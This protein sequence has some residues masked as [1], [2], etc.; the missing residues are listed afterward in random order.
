M[1]FWFYLVCYVSLLTLP[2]QTA[3]AQEKSANSPLVQVSYYV[4]KEGSLRV[5]DIEGKKFIPTPIPFSRGYTP[6]VTWMKVEV[7]PHR[8]PK[9]VLSL[10]P[11]YLDDVRLYRLDGDKGWV[12][13]QMGDHFPFSERIRKERVFAFNITPHPTQTSLFFLRV[14]TT[15]VS[16]FDI[17]VQ[18]E[19]DAIALDSQVHILIGIYLGLLLA[20]ILVSVW[21][22]IRTR[23]V[24]WMIDSFF[25]FVSLCLTIGYMGFSAKYFLPH[26]PLWADAWVSIVALLHMASGNIFLHQFILRYKP[27]RWMIFSFVLID[28]VIP[29]LGFTGLVLGQVQTVMSINALFV[30]IIAPIF[31]IFILFKVDIDDKITNILLRGALLIIVSYL[32]YFAMSFFGFILIDGFHVYPPLL[33]N[34][35]VILFHVTILMRRDFIKKQEI[36]KIVSSAEKIR[37]ELA[38]EKAARAA[39]SSFLSMLLH[40]IRTPM[41]TMRV[42]I[43][44]LASGRNVDAAKQKRRIEKIQNAI[45][46]VDAVLER[47]RETDALDSDKLK[48]KS[49]NVNIIRIA[50]DLIKS[51]GIPHRITIHSMNECIVNIDGILFNMMLNNLLQNAIHYSSMNSTIV[52]KIEKTGEFLVTTISNMVDD[53]CLPDTEMIFQKYYRSNYA[54]RFTGTGL[55]LYWVKGLSH[56]FGGDLKYS[57]L[58][59]QVTF[60]LKLPC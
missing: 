14:S 41:T 39:E 56:R 18:T 45:S 31:N 25:Q 9:L 37:Q 34:L 19:A 27:R 26:K 11:T 55:G 5:E 30:L 15:S 28:Y 43:M 38:L 49:N 51:S 7:A 40:E 20:L 2:L 52:I 57:H 59:N 29:A 42:A 3:Q 48:I 12:F 46:S 36:K 22:F 10:Q 50:N 33:T 44:N 58:E 53:G 6:T 24:L 35:S 32:F 16:L 4:D 54:R 17:K 47:T 1:R 23:D 21:R 13:E 8:E 60:E